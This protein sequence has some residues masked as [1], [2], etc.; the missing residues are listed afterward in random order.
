MSALPETTPA[1]PN[2]VQPQGP[3]AAVPS[4]WVVIGPRTQ[5]QLLRV[6]EQAGGA[7]LVAALE[8]SGHRVED[9]WSLR[10]DLH[11]ERSYGSGP[12]ETAAHAPQ[13]GQG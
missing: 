8:A 12:A 11:L 2:G 5:A 6:L 7:L 10:G 9:G 3:T 4:Q 1:P 13:A